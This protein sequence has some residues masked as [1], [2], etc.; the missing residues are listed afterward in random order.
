MA[1]EAEEDDM[2]NDR[3][4]IDLLYRFSNLDFRE[5]LRLWLRAQASEGLSLSGIHTPQKK[6]RLG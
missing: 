5:Q 3:L 6:L 2:V 4:M 1:N